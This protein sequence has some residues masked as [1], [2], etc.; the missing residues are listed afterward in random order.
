[1]ASTQ[2]YNVV[3]GLNGSTSLINPGIFRPMGGDDTMLNPVGYGESTVAHHMVDRWILNTDIYWTF[4]MRERNAIDAILIF[5]NNHDVAVFFHDLK[6]RDGY[7]SGSHYHAI[8]S[9]R[10]TYDISMYRKL[11][12]GLRAIGGYYKCF[13]IRSVNETFTDL[14]KSPGYFIGTNYEMYLNYFNMSCD[15]QPV[16]DQP[17]NAI[18]KQFTLP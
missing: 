3:F 1:M 10:N 9:T 17:V 8:S 15:D 12:R 18:V 4:S 6:C 13:R 7:T 11:Y 14:R 2:Y 5:L 16:V